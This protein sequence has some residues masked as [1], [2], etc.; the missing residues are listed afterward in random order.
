M[1]RFTRDMFGLEPN[2]VNYLCDLKTF[3]CGKASISVEA[4]STNLE[5]ITAS[6]RSAREEEHNSDDIEE[7]NS[8]GKFEPI[9]LRN[10]YGD[11]IIQCPEC[12]NKS[13]SSLQITHTY[14]C[15]NKGKKADLTHKP[16][17]GG[18]RNKKRKSSK[19]IKKCQKRVTRH[20][21]GR[22]K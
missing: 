12:G 20:S 22:S 8:L 1:I 3:R 5:I 2:I 10:E 15:T 18:S 7:S 21:K 16:K 14:R 4:I 6:S 19:S 11:T 9:Y 17:R 13:G